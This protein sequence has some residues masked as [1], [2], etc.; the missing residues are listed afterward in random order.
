MNS[1]CSVTYSV[2]SYDG[3][4]YYECGRYGGGSVCVLPALEFGHH[5]GISF[6][7]AMNVLLNES[8]GELLVE[9][10]VSMQEVYSKMSHL[11]GAGDN[12]TFE[13]QGPFAPYLIHKDDLCRLLRDMPLSTCITNKEKLEVFFVMKNT[14]GEVGRSDGFKYWMNSG[15]GNRHHVPHV[16]VS[17]QN[18]ASASISLMDSSVLASSPSFPKRRLRAARLWVKDNQQDLLERWND[19]TDGIRADIDMHRGESKL[20]YKR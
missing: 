9:S 11:L 4:D 18:E 19:L 7:N 2:L 13:D 15:E 6:D 3:S 10:N 12:W 5:A 20:F 16:H 14:A 8:R 1:H 17:Y